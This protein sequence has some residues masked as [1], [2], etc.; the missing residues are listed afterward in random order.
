MP[1]PVAFIQEID[2]A[3]ITGGTPVTAFRLT[4]IDL[5]ELD[6]LAALYSREYGRKI[7]RTDTIRTAVTR[8]L[9]AIAKADAK[10]KGKKE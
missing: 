7:N 6:M 9:A 5:R 10:L 8:A 2:M 1:W 4:K 3:T